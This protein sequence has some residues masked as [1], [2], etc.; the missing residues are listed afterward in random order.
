M[1]RSRHRGAGEGPPGAGPP[2]PFDPFPAGPGIPIGPCYGS[3]AGTGE[4]G[5][6]T[7]QQFEDWLALGIFTVLLGGA[8]ALVS[9]H[10]QDFPDV[11]LTPTDDGGRMEL[12]VSVPFG[13]S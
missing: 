6:I 8:D 2:G 5:T 11:T 12:R 7:K 13:G 3:N 10:L 1:P 4:T 9:A